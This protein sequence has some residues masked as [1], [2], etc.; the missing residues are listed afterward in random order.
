MIVPAAPLSTWNWFPCWVTS[1]QN[2]PSTGLQRL[3]LDSHLSSSIRLYYHTSSGC[4]YEAVSH[5]HT[6]WVLSH[7]LH[8]AEQ[9]LVPYQ[10]Q[11]SE[12]AQ[13]TT[14]SSRLL[15]SPSTHTFIYLSCQPMFLPQQAPQSPLS[16][17]P[18]PPPHVL[19]VSLSWA[20]T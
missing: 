12:Q 14:T 4:Y 8:A 2:W 20:V 7:S 15:H 1:F 17:P 5:S 9:Y 19:P 16:P 18:P 6:C 3:P 13:T 10:E 11:S